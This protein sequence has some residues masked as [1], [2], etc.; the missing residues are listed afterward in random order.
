[1]STST[2]RF[3]LGCTGRLRNCWRGY[4][5]LNQRKRME[6][7]CPPRRTQRFTQIG[8]KHFAVRISGAITQWQAQMHLLDES[9]Q[10]N[11][12]D[13]A[14]DSRRE[15]LSLLRGIGERKQLIRMLIH[16]EA[17]ACVPPTLDVDPDSGPLVLDCSVD[18]EQNRRIVASK[19]ISFETTLDKIRIL[20]ASEK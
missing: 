13:Y 10:E 17:E 6:G 18:P 3:P 8:R 1:M 20:F 15:I 19:R 11:W 5:I 2:G 12:H 4:I 16:G 7:C 9:A 14:V